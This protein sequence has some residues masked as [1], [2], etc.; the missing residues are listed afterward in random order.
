MGGVAVF[1]G[2]IKWRQGG[3]AM[4]EAVGVMDAT[5]LWCRGENIWHSVGCLTFSRGR[6]DEGDVLGCIS[7]SCDGKD[8]IANLW[9]P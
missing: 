6:V 5:S 9:S 3:L 8:V 7:A 4:M 2:S 1:S